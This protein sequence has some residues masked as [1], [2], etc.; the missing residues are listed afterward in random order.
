[1]PTVGVEQRTCVHCGLSA[2]VS[3]LCASCGRHQVSYVERESHKRRKKLQ[4]RCAHQEWR[5]GSVSYVAGHGQR[6]DR[7]I[8]CGLSRVMEVESDA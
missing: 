7:C 8:G 4:A 1:M 3:G 6:E 5:E 2:V